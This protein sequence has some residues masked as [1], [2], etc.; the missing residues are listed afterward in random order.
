MGARAVSR[1]R[2]SRI[3]RHLSTFSVY[4]NLHAETKPYIQF[5]SSWA[6]AVS[7]KENL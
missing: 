1:I 6:V 5:F 2:V 7:C 3:R 4:M